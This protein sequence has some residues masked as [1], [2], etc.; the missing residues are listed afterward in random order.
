MAA[1][2][3]LYDADRVPVGDD[4]RQHLELARDL[5]ERFN[6]RY[7][8]TFVIPDAA[9][10]KV[11]ARIMDF[12]DPTIKMSKSRS[13]PQGKLL[14]LEPPESLQRK[15]KRAVTDTENEVRYDPATKPGVSNLL[16]LLSVGTGKP[17][18]ELALGYT[19]Y[20]PLKQDAA[21]AVTELLRPLQE[22]FRAFMDDRAEL[23]RILGE[24]AEKAEAVAS[25]TLARAQQA[26]GLLPRPR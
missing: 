19:Q 17:P 4:Q 5:S 22:G 6:A 23:E 16:E 10:A 26:M 9:I 15:I 11:G 24:G 2:I 12:Q 14:V 8:E 13:S 3:L 18:A 21:M 20:G 1:D 25:K 7:G